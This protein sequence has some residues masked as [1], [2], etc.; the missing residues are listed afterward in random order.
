MFTIKRIWPVLFVDMFQYRGREDLPGSK[1]IPDHWN[2]ISGRFDTSNERNLFC[3]QPG[4]LQYSGE[5]FDTN[6]VAYAI[7]F[8]VQDNLHFEIRGRQSNDGLQYVGLEVNAENKTIQINSIKNTSE[9]II[10]RND[11]QFN[12]KYYSMELCLI[13]EKD[14][15]LIINGS[16]VARGELPHEHSEPN[17]GLELHSFTS[18]S[19]FSAIAVQEIKEFNEPQEHDEKDLYT[20]FR[21][22]IKEQIENP[23][24]KNWQTF[25]N[26]KKL[27]E[28]GRNIGRHDSLWEILGY[29]IEEPR[30]EAWFGGLDN[31]PES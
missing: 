1:S 7:R 23:T 18:P 9:T 20:I 24:E 12:Q 6:N 25:A 31:Q 8:S 22:K 11:Y 16:T 14:Y 3:S 4:I 27:W 29:P 30:P 13:N 17:Y 28:R 21:K 15:Y 19:Y 5:P 10:I 26:A 2:I